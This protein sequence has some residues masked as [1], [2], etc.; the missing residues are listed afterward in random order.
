MCWA[1]V[2]PMAVRFRLLDSN[3]MEKTKPNKCVVCGQP[4]VYV[5]KKT[6]ELLCEK[7][8]GVNEEIRRSKE[9]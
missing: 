1:H 6:G 7:C 2:P 8:M 4:A 3:K 5:L 9:R